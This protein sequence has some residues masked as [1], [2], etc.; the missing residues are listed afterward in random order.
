MF[1]DKPMAHEAWDIDIYYQEKMREVTDI[2]NIELVE[3]GNLRA[4]VR[5]NYK[6]MNTT[7]K[8]RYGS[9]QI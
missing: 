8:S 9:L 6:Y 7:Y 3:N 4:V 2:Q 5:F 1:E